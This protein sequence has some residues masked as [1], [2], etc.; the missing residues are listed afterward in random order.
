MSQD[1]K[2][3]LF[4]MILERNE[5]CRV[6]TNARQRSNYWYQKMFRS[7]NE[8]KLNK[9]MEL[10]RIAYAAVSAFTKKTHKRRMELQRMPK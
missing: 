3:E 4:K 6:R 10:A 2:V 5:L 7:H 9:E 8:D 1:A